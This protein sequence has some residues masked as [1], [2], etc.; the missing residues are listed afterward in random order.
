LL[1]LLE[2]E[3]NGIIASLKGMNT[4][5]RASPKPMSD[6][7]LTTIL[8]KRQDRS[9]IPLFQELPIKLEHSWDSKLIRQLE[10]MA[11]SEMTLRKMTAQMMKH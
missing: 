3:L 8:R 10:T 2:E 7:E 4:S 5:L 6:L 9:T 11:L 1:S